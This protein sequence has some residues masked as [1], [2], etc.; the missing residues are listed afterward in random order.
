VIQLYKLSLVQFFVVFMC[1]FVF[2]QLVSGGLFAAVATYLKTSKLP[3]MPRLEFGV[4]FLAALGAMVGPYLIT[5]GWS[6][7]SD[8]GLP[9]LIA[10]SWLYMDY[11]RMKEGVLDREEYLGD[12]AGFIT[13]LCAILVFVF[14]SGRGAPALEQL[15][16]L[17][18]LF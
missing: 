8:L 12:L 10:L 7:H 15:K 18:N 4:A 16:Q 11:R 6:G 14:A 13:G 2:Y 17:G 9:V 1:G 3:Y 5:L